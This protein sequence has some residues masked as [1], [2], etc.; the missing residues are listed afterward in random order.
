[1][2]DTTWLKKVIKSFC[3]KVLEATDYALYNAAA[4][5]YLFHSPLW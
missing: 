1:M 3:E 4:I 5:F 2:V